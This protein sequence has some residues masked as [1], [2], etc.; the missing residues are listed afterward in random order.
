MPL[1]C[2]EA[3]EVFV[4]VLFPSDYFD[5]KKPDETFSE[6]VHAFQA[7][8]FAVATTPLE[9]LPLG[10][11]K[12]YPPLSE[13]ETVL[14]RGWM[15]SG[16]DYA[17]LTQATAQAGAKPF[18][19]PK[20]YLLTHHIPNWYPHISELTPET[21]CFTD[22]EAVEQRLE[23]LDWQGFFVKD[24]VKSLK[25]SVGSRIE[26]P[27][28]I[29]TVMTEMRKFRGGIE[30]GVCVRR[31]EALEDGS[32]QRYFVI[33]GSAHSNDGEAPPSVVTAC[34]SRLDSPF[35]SVDVATRSDGELRVVEVGDGQVSDLMG[36][37]AQRF[38]SLWQGVLF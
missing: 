11:A 20:Q 3:H 28:Q 19:T 38:A 6:Q 36:W 14:Y 32:E 2:F 1:F 4:T 31:L 24:F 17:L 27:E 35:F 10:K 34:A 30:G 13:S 23:E 33:N 21:V 26:S 22:L 15:L 8:G 37:S 12:F 7:L 9:D 16:D 25:T 5:K 29:R 18:T